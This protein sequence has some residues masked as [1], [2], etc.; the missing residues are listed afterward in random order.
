MTVE[1]HPATAD[2]K[3]DLERLFDSASATRNC[4]C[5]WWR[6]AANAWRD[7]DRAGRRAAFLEFMKRSPAPG[8][9]AYR[10]GMPSAWV[11]ITPRA[12][13][14]RFNA[15]RASRP[16]KDADL[17]GVWAISCFFTAAGARGTGL[18]ETLAR[19]AC[20]FAAGNGATAVEAAAID[21]KP[22]LQW[23]DG[24]VGI[25][26]VLMRAGFEV[27]ERRGKVRTLLRWV[28]G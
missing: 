13:V 16:G 19:A 10:D 6:I 1:V 11:Q 27:V 7:I 20:D 15:G 3:D 5:M 2:R 25:T 23:S 21:A 14:P 22:E 9:L 28:P 18:M 8:L 4:S 12:A 26:P 17:T 24:Y